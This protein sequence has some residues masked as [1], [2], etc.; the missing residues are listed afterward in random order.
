L[1]P[2]GPEV[3][4]FP[5]QLWNSSRRKHNSSVRTGIGLA[6]C[7]GAI[8][9]ES[10]SVIAQNLML[11]RFGIHREIARLQIKG[12]KKSARPPSCVK[13]SALTPKTCYYYDLPLH[14][15]TTTVVQMAAL[16][17]EI[18]DNSVFMNHRTIRRCTSD[19]QPASPQNS[20]TR[21]DKLGLLPVQHLRHG[22]KKLRKNARDCLLDGFITCHSS[23]VAGS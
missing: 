1:V 7:L 14:R 2:A 22:K 4:R 11:F 13:F 20:R 15:A 3:R 16:V 10:E 23:K 12:R 6:R 18:M 17:R 8:P 21:T 9:A 5:E 19:H